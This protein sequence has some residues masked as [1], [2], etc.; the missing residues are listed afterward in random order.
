[1]IYETVVEGKEQL[2]AMDLDDSNS[3][4]LTR[5]PNGHENPA[6]CP[7]SRSVALV[8]NGAQA[9]ENQRKNSLLN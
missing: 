2:F 6:W 7:D 9:D 8:G 4:Q 3:I 1:M 5:G